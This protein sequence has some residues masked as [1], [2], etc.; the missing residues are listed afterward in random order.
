MRVIV[1]GAGL[2]GLSA[3]CHL[4]SRHDVLVL[5]REDRPGATAGAVLALEHE[6]VVAAREVARGRQAAE[7]GTITITRTG[8]PPRQ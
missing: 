3:A 6:D 5:E 4:S 7:A 2:G 8:G 1:I